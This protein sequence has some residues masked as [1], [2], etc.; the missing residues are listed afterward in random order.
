MTIKKLS[1]KLRSLFRQRGFSKTLR[2]SLRPLAVG[3]SVSV[4]SF[5]IL[6]GCT[7]NSTVSLSANAI[8]N[9]SASPSPSYSATGGAKAVKIIFS[10]TSSGSFNP[11]SSG[12]TVAA[13][14][15][16]LQAVRV[17]NP[18]GTVLASN[19][20]TGSNWPAWLAG[21]ELGISGTSNTSAKNPYCATFAGST[22]STDLSCN[23]GSGSGTS[24]CGAPPGQFRISEVDC[25]AGAPAASSGN[26][27]PS[28]GIYFR[29]TFSRDPSVL[30]LNENIL[31]VLEYTASALNPA[32]SNPV[33]CFTGGAFT[34]EACT[35]FV[36]R[37]YIKHS[38]SEIVQPFL[39]LIP[40][41]FSSVLVTNI[42]S[43]LVGPQG[44]GTG[45]AAKQF[46]VPLASDS[47]IKVLQVTRKQSAFPDINTL[48][49]YCSPG[50]LPGNSPLC[51]G[52]V[53]Y[54]ITFYR[55]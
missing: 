12:G 21:F 38:A 5:A 54:S 9:P 27:G 8:S 2:R 16:G 39:M 1:K 6:Q 31:V 18:D 50:S 17:F 7:P 37:T 15:S 19:G 26:G 52:V 40:P 23:F 32:P 25:S 55:I 42:P 45:V 49:S 29:A 41:T 4:V 47:G 36:W 35:D 24:A 3:L 20:P 43:P 44:S 10:D 13:P 30:A 51:A 22:E 48:K 14:G 11:P 33:N 28:D 53:L 34:P 46:I